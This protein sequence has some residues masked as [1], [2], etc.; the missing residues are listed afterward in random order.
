MCGPLELALRIAEG[1]FLGIVSCA[2]DF[3]GGIGPIRQAEVIVVR[4][5]EYAKAVTECETRD[6]EDCRRSESDEG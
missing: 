6:V 3:L 2:G 4:V 5:S 1:V